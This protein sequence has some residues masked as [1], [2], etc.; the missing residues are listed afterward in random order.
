MK[1]KRRRIQSAAA[2]LFHCTVRMSVGVHI[3]SYAGLF[4]HFMQKYARSKVTAGRTMVRFKPAVYT[5]PLDSSPFRPP[6]GPQDLHMSKKSPPPQL[7]N[8]A[9]RRLMLEYFYNRNKNATSSREQAIPTD[10]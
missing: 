6:N 2:F 8:T 7:D 5:I 9:I 4:H 3:S 1:G 10:P